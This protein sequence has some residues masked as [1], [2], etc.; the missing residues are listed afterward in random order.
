MLKRT[1]F[2]DP[3]GLALAGLWG[4][5][6][7]WAAGANENLL[8]LNPLCLLLP[9]MWSRTP[10]L[11][12]GLA[13]LIAAAALLALVIRALPGLYQ[14]NLAFI[15][16]AVPVHLVLAVLAWRQRSLAGAPPTAVS[17]RGSNA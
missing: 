12:R 15:A 10:Q 9:E 7:H 6:D 14:D 13:T 11:A 3:C 4:L 1:L 8:L 17:T 16:L 2:T 5:T